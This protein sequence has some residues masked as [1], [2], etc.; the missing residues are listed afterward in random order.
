MRLNYYLVLGLFLFGAFGY[1]QQTVLDS[2]EVVVARNTRDEEM[3]KTLNRIS[4][5]YSRKDIE[6]AKIYAW[7][8]KSLSREIGN[9]KT[10][11]TSYSHL[12]TLHKN[13]GETDSAAFYLTSLKNLTDGA[14]KDDTDKLNLTYHSTAGLYFKSIGKSKT[15]LPHLLNAYEIAKRTSNVTDASGQALNVGNCY[16]AFADYKKALDY[17]L[18][19]LKGFE[20]MGNKAG[21][22]FCYNSI[23]NCY[24][25]LKLNEQSLQYLQKSYKLKTELGDRQGL[26]NTN[27][28]FGN[29]Y[30]AMGDLVKAE[31]YF[32]KAIALNTEMENN[33]GLMQNYFNMG[34]L[35]S[36]TNPEKAIS[37]FE[38]SKALAIKGD[39]S[40]MV[41][42]IELEMLAVKNLNEKRPESEREAVKNLELLSN[43]G[44]KYREVYG[45]QNLA[46][47]YTQ[48]KQFDKALEYTR[49]FHDLKDSLKSEE[50]QLHFKTIEERY[51]KEKNE[52][53]ITLLRKDKEIDAQKLK[54]QRSWIIIF[55]LLT[56]LAGF[57]IWVIIS[58][59]RVRQQMK[60]LELRNGIAA[61]LHDEVGS[62]LSSIYML[63]QLAGRTHPEEGAGILDKVK[64][65]AKETMEKMDDIV[66]MIK[67]VNS[68]SESLK[69]R[70]RRFI[71]EAC[72][73]QGIACKLEI[74]GLDEEKLTVPQKKNLYLVFKEAVNNVFKY[75]DTQKLEIRI[76]QSSKELDMLIQDYGK[77]FEQE[78]TK[79]G[80]GIQNM[81]A[82][83]AELKGKLTVTSRYGEGTKIQLDFPLG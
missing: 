10:L 71:L 18:I 15:A 53:Q 26:T 40:G 1:P 34:R 70:I 14:S 74:D 64:T 21:Q 11:G 72:E 77:G 61:D 43:E 30:M 23:S 82:R 12:V 75:A 55:G 67:P 22:S 17:F 73:L 56:L 7:K 3:A 2:L 62:S 54:Q 37:Y 79:K 38:K 28:N 51:N 58:R 52:K 65:N 41:S 50:I 78:N 33:S 60:E 47:Y 59:S 42:R 83:A 69:E 80:N 27:Q 81:K 36:E 35:Y 9:N 31:K 48:T 68:Q 49:K 8:A 29:I 4:W 19:A 46:E 13:A 66:W 32:N 44:V 24:Y 76:A 6:K 16:Y 63:S 25:E 57:G 45:Y 39:N 20:T 5:E